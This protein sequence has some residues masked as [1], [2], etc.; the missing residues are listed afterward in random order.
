MRKLYLF[1]LTLLF[2]VGTGAVSYGQYCTVSYPATN[3]EPITFVKFNSISNRTSAALTQPAYENFTVS[4]TA[5]QTTTVFKEI[6]Y[7]MTVEGNTNGNFPTNI[8]VYIDWN[9]N[10]LFTDA[11]EHYTIGT[12][13]NSTGA[14]GKS[15]SL[16]ITIPAGIANGAKRMRVVKNFNAPGGPCIVGTTS[17]Y[18]QVEDYTIT[19]A[20]APNCLT[21]PAG[22]TI[23]GP[24]GPVCPNIPFVLSIS[25]DSFGLGLSY[26]WQSS[27]DGSTWTDIPGATTPNY[28]ASHTTLTHYRR[29]TTCSGQSD[30]STSISVGVKPIID[31]YCPSG[32]E[33]FN[34]E[35]IGNVTITGG[36]SNAT[37]ASSY[38]DY[39]TTHVA[40]VFQGQVVKVTIDQGLTGWET[41]DVAY[42]Y[43]DF[44]QDGDFSDPGEF[45][46]SKSG[47]AAP[48]VISFT[49]PPTAT[50]GNTRLRIKFGDTFFL[51]VVNENDPCQESY[52]YG[53]VEDYGLLITVPPSCIPVSGLVAIPS[54][55][56]EELIS[57]TASATNPSNGY[58]W[59]V[60]Q[61]GDG[62]SGTDGLV[63]SG[64]TAAGVTSATV[65]G[66]SGGNTYFLWVRSDCGG[67]DLSAWDGPL[68]FTTVCDP[69]T[70]PFVQNFDAT[71]EPDQPACVVIQDANGATSWK[72]FFGGG[73][74]ASSQPV[75]IRYEWD[76][77]TPADDWFFLQGITL[78]GG[79]TYTLSFKYK[80]SNGPAFV[81]NLEVK[82]GTAPN[83]AGMTAGT[84]FRELS[85]ATAV[86][87]PFAT[88]TATFTPAADGVYYI[89]FHAFS[90]ADQAFLYVDDITVESCQTPSDLK[91]FSS[92][93][94]TAEVSFVSAGNSF[95]VEY[96]PVGFTPGT[97]A[98]A[99]DGTLVPG[100]TGSPVNITGLT[101]ETEYDIYVRQNCGGA[102]YS[103]NAHVTVRTLCAA[104]VVPYLVNFENATAP[105]GYPSCTSIFD[106]NG[107]SG[108]VPNTTGGQYIIAAGT[109]PDTYVS[110]TRTLRYIYDAANT[111]RGAD[112]WFFLQGLQLTG[113]VKY[114]LKFYYKASDGPAFVEALEVKYGTSAHP[115]A[116]TQSVW[117]NNNINTAVASPW[118]SAR[119]DITPAA[120]GVYY[121]GFHAKSAP[122]QGFL[123]LDDISVRP[124][125]VVD[126]G[127]PS[128]KETLPTCPASNFVMTAKVV[129]YNLTPLNLATY[130]ITVTASITGAA[131]S[132]LTATV[133]TGTIAPGDTL[134]VP[135]TAF[136]FAAGLHNI[137]F[138]VSNPNDTENGNDS[139][140]TSVYVNPTPVAA[141]FTP[142]NPQNC[143]QIS[144]QFAAA[145]PPSVEMP[146]VTTGTITVAIPD[147]SAAGI[148]NSL[149]VTGIP[150]GAQVTGVRVVLN[151]SHTWVSD[152]TI[153]LRAPN[154]RVLNL[155]NA[156]GGNGVNLT[157]TVIS[158]ASTTPIPATGA[159]YTGTYRA[160]AAANVGPTGMLSNAAAFSDLFNVGNG[161]WTLGLRDRVNGDLG[162]LTSWSIVVTYG[163]PHPAVT[164]A[165]AT[166]LF[167][168]AAGTIPYVA[169]TSA[170]AVYANPATEITYTVTSTAAGC[171][172]SS[173]VTVKPLIAVANWPAKICIS[174]EQI[175][176][177]ATPAGGTWIGTGISGNTFL[178][179]ST[180]VGTYPLTYRYTNA[181]GCV[182]TTTVVAKV[183]DCPERIRLLRDDAV[184]LFPN[185]TRGQLN[186]RINS[187][188]YNNLNMRVYTNS[189]LLVHNRTLTNLAFGRVI[190]VD[191]TMLPAGAYMVQFFYDGGVRT[192]DK[193]F[194]V[195]ITK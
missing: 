175:Q 149:N 8:D 189:G 100:V 71:I 148:T 43:A 158:S 140:I 81:E 15:V 112:D 39:S 89:G 157:N 33:D 24:A 72:S 163:F 13:V 193:T 147:N 64:T 183:E 139:Y 152:L 18:G 159:P 80:A 79:K 51:A 162:V 7:T 178:P 37:D 36:V 167:T 17:Q 83:I 150:A 84:L 186:I 88:A 103:L 21:P 121:F 108:P 119:V 143:A 62:G 133:N 141:V 144:T 74:A 56:T 25:G 110:P 82:Y 117:E 177:S 31:C 138:K 170:Y 184:I 1:L 86:A 182:S 26:Q 28:T 59:E 69:A 137:T 78:T 12:I 41:S 91:A 181:S 73:Q 191:L 155:I 154:G 174:D 92:T 130:P 67:G 188:L 19:V 68:Q 58:I 187:V 120:T 5:S 127:I 95:V 194:P 107:S 94:T 185:P 168:D 50:L 2:I 22:G 70:V 34:F 20:T 171:T 60:R 134:Q 118:D 45:V 99:G 32:S 153:N 156:K 116:M 164:W 136:T 122:D 76:A 109:T 49:V 111:S 172:N 169:G 46:G 65:T 90:D 160:D 132:T 6:I 124:S 42:V 11:G 98:T 9:N 180:A 115:S 53:E 151:V 54:S 23:A 102:E 135:L 192:S 190:P 97:D 30:P 125:P 77:A 114:R 10:Q 38:S 176:L 57:W 66:L 48:Y 40:T 126:A 55:P 128:I 106:A 63:T 93:P 52:S 161:T 104:T 87:S 27:P 145:P 173:T 123:Y 61:Y 85:I 105:T 14:D 47:N 131:T 29:I 179:A 44:N 142:A 3:V 96:G 195:I 16:D 101:P 75:S 165:P 4:P 129:N 113:G 166:G 146:A 35:Y